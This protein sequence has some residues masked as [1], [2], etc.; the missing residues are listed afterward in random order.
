MSYFHL[1]IHERTVMSQ[2]HTSGVSIRAIAEAIGR[3]PSTVSRELK[4][5]SYRTGRDYQITRYIPSTA[6]R[7]Y[8]QRKTRCG[9]KRIDDR[10][11]LSHIKKRIEEHWSPEQIRGRGNGD[12]KLPSVSTI[13]RMIRKGRLGEI[14]MEKLRRKGCFKRPCEARGKFNDGGRTIKKRDRSVYKRKELGHWE[15]DTVVSGKDDRTSKSKV[16]FV[17]LAERKSRLYLAIKVPDRSAHSVTPAIIRALEEYPSDL[18]KTIT[19]DRGKEFSGYREIEEALN[20]K[21]YF[22]DPYCSWQKGTNENTNGLLREFYPKGM[23][24]SEVS[25]EDLEKKTDLLNSRPR[26]CLNY[27]TPSEVFNSTHKKPL[28]LN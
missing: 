17:T 12:M 27:Q 25:E 20:C 6:Q 19:F 9:R 24:L 5:N 16:C 1:N 3:S 23:D 28:R 18:V 4:R 14:T 22:C 21:T 8:E 2:L 10:E 26:K 11:V 7:Y 15:G 13:Y